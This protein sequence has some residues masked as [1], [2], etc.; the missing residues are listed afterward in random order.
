VLEVPSAS[1]NGPNIAVWAVTSD[2]EGQ[3][4]R[5]GRPAINTVLIPSG[6]KNAFNIGDPADDLEDFGDEVEATITA[7]S[8]PANAAAL[9]PVLLPDV[10]TFDTS[11]AAGFLNGRQLADDVIDA[12]LNL[13]TEGGLT[14]DMVDSN[15]ATFLNVFPYL[16]APNN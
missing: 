5:M 16:A 4:D 6:Q 9:T 11:S 10:L 14:T 1:L 13:L 3:F 7:L 2:V 8:S 12:E 15:D